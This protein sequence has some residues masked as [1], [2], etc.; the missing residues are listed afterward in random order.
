[1]KTE[2]VSLGLNKAK[3]FLATKCSHFKSSTSESFMV[4]KLLWL[5]SLHLAAHLKPINQ[6]LAQKRFQTNI[7]G[8][9]SLIFRNSNA[10]YQDDAAV[11][12]KTT[13]TEIS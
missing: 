13:K 2:K 11:Y 9:N 6:K 4:L 7:L 1:M 3:K 8:L 12:L 5:D 10:Q